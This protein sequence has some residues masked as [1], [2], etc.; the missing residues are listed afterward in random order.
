MAIK[1]RSYQEKLK[2]LI[3]GEIKNGHK[4]VLAV[5]PT[6]GGKTYTM[7]AIAADSLEKG[8]GVLIVVHRDN[9]VNQTYQSLL[10]LGFTRVGVVKAGWPAPSHKDR[11]IVASLQSLS[12]RKLPR[13]G[14]KVAIIVDECHT[15][16]FYTSMDKIRQHYRNTADD[17]IE[18][19]FTAT[20]YR[21]KRTEYMG[22]HYSALSRTATIRTL[23]EL[24]RK[25]DCQ[26]LTRTIYK[27]WNGLKNFDQIHMVGGE[28]DH[29]EVAKATLDNEWLDKCVDLTIAETVTRR[30]AVFCAS[31]KQA[32]V[33]A[34][35][36]TASG[37]T[38]SVITGDTPISDRLEIYRAFIDGGI[39]FLCGVGCFTEG[40]DC[41][42]CDSIA[43]MLPIGSKAKYAQV[44]GRGIRAFPGKL[45]CLILDFCGNFDR[46]GSV[47]DIS[48]DPIELFPEIPDSSGMPTK[49]CPQCG[50][51]IPQTARVCPECGHVFPKP[52]SSDRKPTNPA[53]WGLKLTHKV[54]SRVAKM[55]R[56]RFKL[57]RDRIDPQM[58]AA[59]YGDILETSYLYGSCFKLP[60]RPGDYLKFRDYLLGFTENLDFIDWH[61]SAE[62]GDGRQN[63]I[64]GETV[65]F[66]Y[67]AIQWWQILGCFP[68]AHTEDVMRAYQVSLI[69]AHNDGDS[70]RLSLL[71]YAI[72]KF[73]NDR[74]LQGIKKIS[75]I[76]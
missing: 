39:K 62:F 1:L 36:L 58:L 5:L 14:S 63:P 7:G 66:T 11:V 31:V 57:Y 38:A 22:M 56:L 28:F 75:Q 55:R 15:V 30:V 4:A 47:E 44:I 12:R 26:G 51:E 16:A 70:D 76:C 54:K 27:G 65:R 42:I 50:A 74:K 23:Q 32:N 49:E 8:R 19:G 24:N 37:Q 20:P 53:G 29:K 3:Y 60:H 59:D 48:E 21:A 40:W 25:D 71:E 69:N 64:T 41:P 52:K 67:P 2:R 46:H 6:G 61:L 43:I 13:L 9:L 34:D 35:K 18:M 10:N 17:V 33:V 68:T 73:L 45:D 72:E